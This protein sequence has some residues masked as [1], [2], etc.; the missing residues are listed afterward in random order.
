MRNNSKNS[1]ELRDFKKG[2]SRFGALA[3]ALV[4]GLTSCSKA[5]RPE[6]WSTP[7]P[8]PSASTSETE[9]NVPIGEFEKGEPLHL[10]LDQALEEARTRVMRQ[11][12]WLL[13]DVVHSPDN[14][15]GPIGLDNPGVQYVVGVHNGVPGDHLGST[16]ALEPVFGNNDEL[17]EVNVIVNAYTNNDERPEGE[18]LSGEVVGV[19][20][21]ILP[22]GSMFDDIARAKLSWHDIYEY[23]RGANLY[24]F[25]ASAPDENGEVVSIDVSRGSDSMEIL[26]VTSDR[27]SQTNYTEEYAALTEELLGQAQ[28]VFEKADQQMLKKV[29]C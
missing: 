28:G 5:D 18:D 29:G 16:L 23:L 26:T 15:P 10:Q 27:E 11:S 4:L 2:A 20:A 19:R 8:V 9:Q 14:Q 25:F 17:A 3:A 13:S 12:D 22:T 7:G 21:V 24:G 6:D 1:H